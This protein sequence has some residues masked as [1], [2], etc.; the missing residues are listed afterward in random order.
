MYQQSEKETNRRGIEKKEGQ[1][2]AK[3]YGNQGRG[4]RFWGLESWC[5]FSPYWVVRLLGNYLLLCTL[6]GF[7]SWR[8]LSSRH[9]HSTLLQSI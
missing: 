9:L 8:Y 7:S 5:L 1:R 2:E 6:V 4:I 3:T